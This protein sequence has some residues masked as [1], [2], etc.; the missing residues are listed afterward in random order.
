MFVPK[1]T[2]VSVKLK[3]LR[4]AP[5]YLQKTM[6]CVCVDY[7]F[8]CLAKVRTSKIKVHPVE[9]NRSNSRVCNKAFQLRSSSGPVNQFKCP[10][11]PHTSL[12]DGMPKNR[13]WELHL[14]DERKENTASPLIAALSWFPFE[15]SLFSALV[16]GDYAKR[17]N[18]GRKWNRNADRAICLLLKTKRLINV[19]LVSFHPHGRGWQ[20]PDCQIN[21]L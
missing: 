2:I 18:R 6:P 9:T 10:L 20:N 5:P 3:L 4:Y 15:W 11:H 19:R 14:R 7:T 16:L 8:K 21:Q 17:Q 13:P 1:T 12:K